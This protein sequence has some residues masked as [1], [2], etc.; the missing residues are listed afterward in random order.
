[1]RNSKRAPVLFTE[2]SK[3]CERKLYAHFRGREQMHCTYV[4]GDV[5]CIRSYPS[6]PLDVYFTKR[7]FDGHYAGR[8]SIGI[9]P[10]LK[11]CRLP[12]TSLSAARDVCGVKYAMGAAKPSSRSL[13]SMHRAY[14]VLNRFQRDRKSIFRWA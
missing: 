5:K 4:H 12:V 9:I 13:T 6:A 14:P 11:V 10:S 2:H 3:A 8:G 7:S 1:M